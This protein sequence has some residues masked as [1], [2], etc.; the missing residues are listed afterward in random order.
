[1]VSA[2]GSQN[3]NN[4]LAEEKTA[5]VAAPIFKEISFTQSGINFLNTIREDDTHNFFNFNYIYNGSGLAIGDFNNDD[6]KDIYFVSNQSRNRLFLNKGS[7]KFENI[8]D[9]A[10]VSAAKGWK[11]GV[12]VVDINQDGLDDI[13]LSR[14]GRYEDPNERANYLY[15]NNGDLTFTESAEKYGLADKGYGIQAYFFDY[16]RDGDLDLYQMNHRLD[17]NNKNT[18]MFLRNEKPSDY[19]PYS[20]DRLYENRGGRYVDISDRSGIV[21]SAWGLSAVMGDF[22]ED[23]WDDI[24]VANDYLTPDFLYIN[25]QDGTFTESIQDYFQHMSFFSMGSDWADIDNNGHFDLVTLDMAPED[26]VRSKRLMASMSNEFFR[27]M[28][29]Q[30]LQ[31]QYMINS[32]Q[33]NHGD[34][35]F[36]EV[37]QV[38]G[39]DKT[40]WSW[41]ALFGDY[42]ADGLKDLYITNGIRKDI[43]DNDAVTASD[44]IFALGKQVALG[45]ILKLLPS[46]KLQNPV[47]QNID[48]L[49]FKRKNVE[50]GLKRAFNSNGAVYSDLDNDGDLEIITNNMDLMCTLN[51]NLTVENEGVRLRKITVVGPKGNR[52]GFGTTL[53]IKTTD[54]NTVLEKVR[55]SR[56]YL[57]SSDRAIYLSENIKIKEIEVEWPTGQ[58]SVITDL[59]EIEGGVIDYQ[60]AAFVKMSVEEER[61]YFTEADAPIIDF[62]H[63]ENS[64]DDFIKEILLPHRQSEHGPFITKA[65]VNGDGLEDV[66]IG[67]AKDQSGSLFVQQS[68]GQ[69]VKSSQSTFSTDAAHEDMGST[70]FDADGDN[71]LDLYVVSGSGEFYQGNGNLLRDRLYLNDGSGNFSRVSDAL[72]NDQ[73]G[74]SK[75]LASDI[76]NDGDQDLI[77]I[78]RNVPG[79]YPKGPRSFV[80]LNE[81]GRFVNATKNFSSD[82]YDASQ[83]LTDGVLVDIDQNGFEDLVVV[84]EWMSPKIYMND[85]EEFEEASLDLD[86]LKGWWQSIKPTD[87]DNDGDID[88][89]VGN[90]GLNNKFHPK[91]DSPLYLFYNDFDENGIGD[92]VLSKSNGEELLPVRGRECS[93]QQMP[94]ILEKFD[95]YEK[96]ANADLT[97]IY[98]EERLEASLKLEVNNFASGILI[99]NGDMNFEFKELPTLSQFGAVRDVILKDV[100]GDGLTDLICAGNF[101]GSEVETVRYDSSF[102]SIVINKGNNEFETLSLAESGLVLN[103]DV[104]DLETVTVQ[105]DEYL[106]VTSNNDELKSYKFAKRP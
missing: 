56:G 15:I 10:G 28:V 94:F 61:S 20:R 64:F 55:G 41:T 65:D 4:E 66:Y 31:H 67:G 50:W 73:I 70:F 80:Y 8:T 103:S 22:N 89:V 49:K 2:C 93:S 40:D 75:A 76:D 44:S 17:F 84:G 72:P 62:K 79:E 68:S 57:S 5:P 59:K 30:G 98:S 63:D 7:L 82:I 101:F 87:I 85:G 102:G 97:A 16:D 53:R 58:S 11:N 18:I 19:D 26:H 74:G 105:S 27:T 14:S 34:G 81:G 33:Y 35:N 47:Y 9:S 52:E 104:R 83:M 12:T 23:G 3:E 77:V 100:N 78:N 42:N 29:D 25:N 51:Q 86:N 13:Y 43:T 38:S 90:I 37:S 32:L 39:I 69:Y 46:Q 48:G 99:N 45:Q 71:D 88:F 24:Y 60:N 54:G 1:M 36:S 6:L 91:P 95:N 92:I 21:N 96:F 106:L